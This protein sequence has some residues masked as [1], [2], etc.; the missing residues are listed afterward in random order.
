MLND[1]GREMAQI[2]SN[3]GKTITCVQGG[4]KKITIKFGKKA[5]TYSA[6]YDNCREN[7]VVRDSIYEIETINDEVVRDEEKPTKNRELFDAA[8]SDDIAKV[9]MQIKNKADV[10]ISYKMPLVAGGEVNGWTPL[11]SAVLNG[12]LELVKLLVKEGAWINHLNSDVRN[13]LWHA[14][15][16]GKINIVKYLLKNGSFVNNSD[17]TDT[18]PLM[19]AAINGDTEIVKLLIA[20]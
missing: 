12:N 2:S 18:T 1:L 14:T 3:N 16:T 19:K 11:T 7:N 20:Y 10:N 6:Y 4:T 8:V 9:T 15:S 5:S 13:A 17:I